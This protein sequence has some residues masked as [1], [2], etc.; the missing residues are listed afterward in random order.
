MEENERWHPRSQLEEGKIHSPN[1]GFN[2]LIQSHVPQALPIIGR[3]KIAETPTAFRYCRNWITATLS[4]F[5]QNY[6][7]YL[8]LRAKLGL[9]ANRRY[10]KLPR[11]T[12]A[13]SSTVL[14]DRSQKALQSCGQKCSQQIPGVARPC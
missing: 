12:T 2:H 1:S 10:R 7:V 6:S 5:T 9:L 4:M 11:N 13:L 3:N 14:S 8:E